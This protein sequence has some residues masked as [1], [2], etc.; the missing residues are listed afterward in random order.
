MKLSLRLQQIDSMVNR[1]YDHIWDCCCDH[2]FLGINLLQRRA[3]KTVHFVDIVPDL[4]KQIEDRLNS[5][6]AKKLQLNTWHAHCVDA[7]ALPVDLYSNEPLKDK[8]LVIIAGVGGELLIEL[9]LSLLE[10]F[11][12]Y[13]VEFL[14]CPVHHN[15]KVRQFLIEQ[16][17]G[18]INESLICDNKRYYEVLHVAVDAPLPV[19]NV[20]S[21][22]W[23]FN[24]KNHINYLDKTIQHYQRIAK[25]PVNN[26]QTVIEQYQRLYQ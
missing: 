15:Y 7:A 8:H 25:S 10:R 21:I 12:D 16:K 19:S 2:G 5:D 26:T 1:E 3:A 17:L 23:D 18:L 4:L 24:N 6:F 11:S 22:M 14:L 20:G 9:M 13:Q